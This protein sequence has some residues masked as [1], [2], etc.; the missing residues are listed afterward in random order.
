MVSPSYK[1]PRFS[2]VLGC[3]HYTA[4]HNFCQIKIYFSLKKY[5]KFQKFIDF[6]QIILYHINERRKKL[7][8]KIQLKRMEA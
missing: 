1:K 6:F 2:R 4:K 8:N 5:K 3:L 7:I